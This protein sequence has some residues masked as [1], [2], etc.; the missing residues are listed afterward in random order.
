MLFLIS[1]RFVGHESEEITRILEE[2]RITPVV[3]EDG[4]C[5]EFSFSNLIHTKFDRNVLQAFHD[6]AKSSVE[7]IRQGRPG[8]LALTPAEESRQLVYHLR[9]VLFDELAF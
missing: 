1:D 9:H 7:E 4:A 6:R 5:N 8:L 3:V 2:N